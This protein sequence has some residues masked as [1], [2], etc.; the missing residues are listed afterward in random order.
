MNSRKN[1][2]IQSITKLNLFFYLLNI[3]FFVSY[4][5]TVIKIFCHYYSK[6]S[7]NQDAPLFFQLNLM[8]IIIFNLKVNYASKQ[9][10][11]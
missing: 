2:N 3:L 11:I 4:T 8:T 1:K 10:G 5:V 9:A 7:T 6:C